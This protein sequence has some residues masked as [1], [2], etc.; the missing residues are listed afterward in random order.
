MFHWVLICLTYLLFHDWLIYLIEWP[1]LV[2]RRQGCEIPVK[3]LDGLLS[4]LEEKKRKVEQQEEEANM[5]IL[6]D[7][8]RCLRNL[9]LD[10]LNE[11]LPHEFICLPLMQSYTCWFLW[12]L[13]CLSFFF[14]KLIFKQ[15]KEE[16]VEMLLRGF[17][18]FL[19]ILLLD[20][21]YNW[22]YLD[23]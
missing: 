21:C 1:F 18:K 2:L 7:F 4:L 17:E 8:L 11:V 23:S 10:E 9:K 16:W 15:R 19:E 22:I 12:N 14:L 13:Y 3:E 6:C 20:V 5:Q